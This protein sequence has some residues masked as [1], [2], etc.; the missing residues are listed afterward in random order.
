MQERCTDNFLSIFID[1]NSLCREDKTDLRMGV[2]CDGNPL[3]KGLSATQNQQ[4]HLEN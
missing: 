4:E 1:Y 2:E 3:N